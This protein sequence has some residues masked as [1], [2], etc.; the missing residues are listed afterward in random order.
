MADEEQTAEPK[1]DHEPPAG[2]ETTAQLDRRREADSATPRRRSGS[3]CARRRSPPPRS[4]PSRTSPTAATTTRPVA[5]VFNGGPG[6]SSA[7]LHMGAVGPQRVDFPA[8]GT[9]PE[10][11]PKLVAERVLVARVRRPR[12]RRPGRH[13]L[14]P[15]HRARQEGRRGE[16]ARAAGRR[17]EAGSGRVLRPEARPRVDVRVHGSLA[18][19]ERPLGLS[20]LH[21]RRELRRLPRRPARADAAGGDRHRPQRRDPDLAGARADCAR[22]RAT[23]A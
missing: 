20:G 17:R 8:D 15:H 6:A 1:K 2:A 3:S 12:L 18:V 21:R 11:P 19:R 16:E 7:Y 23:T 10:L 14:Q 5:F 4:S 22:L 13:R 9:L